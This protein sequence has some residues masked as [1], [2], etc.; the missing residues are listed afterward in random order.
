MS[1][2]DTVEA[3]YLDTIR[4]QQVEWYWHGRIAKGKLTCFDGLPG[5]GKTTAGL[6]LVARFS[7]G[8]TLPLERLPV[9]KLVVGILSDED[10]PADTTVPR[11]IIAGADRTQICQLTG[12]TLAGMKRSLTIPDDLTEIAM[13]VRSEGIGYLHVDPLA[14]HASK[15][16]DLY[17]DQDV[18][19]QIMGPL[20]NLAAETGVAIVLVRHP[21]K[22]QTGPAML[23][24]GGSI[25]IIGAA[26]FGL[27]FG[28]DPHDPT[29]RVIASTKVNIGPRPESLIFTLEG[30]AD[31][32]HA[33]VCWDPVP[34]D[35]TAD[36]LLP[37]PARP[38]AKKVTEA[39]GWLLDFLEHGARLATDTIVA[40]EQAGHTERTLKRAKSTLE[41]L[42]KK[43]S[44]SGVW[45]W[46]LPGQE[47]PLDIETNL[48]LPDV[49]SPNGVADYSMDYWAS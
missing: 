8:D 4:P 2:G 47:P 37:M 43:T 32:D 6:D 21:T 28:H 16:V 48:T 19:A 46:C 14:A 33:R 35:L 22:A 49:H 30:V 38:S 42:S 26:R 29:R 7:R 39:E 18:R 45:F 25:G 20:A 27:F 11:L 3:T 15:G 36:E 9:P 34:S 40:G 24:G 1:L 12:R 5:M 41:I 23:R 10:D 17:V 31:S 44:Y 13:L